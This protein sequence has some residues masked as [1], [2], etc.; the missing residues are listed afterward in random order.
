MYLCEIVLYNYSTFVSCVCLCKRKETDRLLSCKQRSTLDPL[1]FTN[2]HGQ[3][4]CYWNHRGIAPQYIEGGPPWSE[5][6]RFMLQ[7]KQLPFYMYVT[8]SSILMAENQC[9][10]FAPLTEKVKA[11]KDAPK[12]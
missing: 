2:V 10:G 8:I 12:P 11:I 6:S 1:Q 4:F 7:E 3:Y 9:S 5:N